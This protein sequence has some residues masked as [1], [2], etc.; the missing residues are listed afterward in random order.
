MG[1]LE[2]KDKEIEFLEH[3]AD[4]YFNETLRLHSWAVFAT[5]GFIM[6]TIAFFIVVIAASIKISS[7]IG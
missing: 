7:Y 2:I 5:V 3:K 1:E 6:M 4:Q